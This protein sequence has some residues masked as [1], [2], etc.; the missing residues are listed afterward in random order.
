ME[1]NFYFESNW[2]KK[3][4]KTQES[5]EAPLLN[6]PSL[7]VLY[8]DTNEM[9]MTLKPKSIC[10]RLLSVALACAEPVCGGWVSE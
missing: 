4:K 5:H 2:G 1:D 10:S 8:S 9:L 6:F 3:K 7:P